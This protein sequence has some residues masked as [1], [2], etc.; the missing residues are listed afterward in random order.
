M[1]H[2]L[3]FVAESR[4]VD[5]S[6]LERFAV[7]RK[8][9]YGLVNDGSAWEV[10][11]WHVDKLIADFKASADSPAGGLSRASD[12]GPCVQYRPDHRDRA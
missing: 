12:S 10:S 11:T 8:D 9:Q 2:R 7:E 6:A 4:R 5:A 1:W 3:S